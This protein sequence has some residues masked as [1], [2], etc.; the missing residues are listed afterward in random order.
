MP[1]MKSIISAFNKC[2]TSDTVKEE[3]TIH[4]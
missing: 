1:G 4:G 2:I 3:L